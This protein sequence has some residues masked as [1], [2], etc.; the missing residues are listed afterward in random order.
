MR[1]D[2]RSLSIFF[3]ILQTFPFLF[4]ACQKDEAI[5]PEVSFGGTVHV[6]V[7]ERG[8]TGYTPVVWLNRPAV[9]DVSIFLEVTGNA[10]KDQDFT[11]NNPIYV[12]AGATAVPL[13][14][15]IVD[16]QVGEPDEIA[17]FKLSHAEG[18]TVL[19]R[20]VNMEVQIF[21]N[22]PSGNLVIQTDALPGHDLDLFLWKETLTGSGQFEIVKYSAHRSKFG[23][24]SITILASDPD[25]VYG[26]SCVY[27]EGDSENFIFNLF[28]S[29]EDAWTTQQTHVY[30][31]A[32]LNQGEPQIREMY[33]TKK[34]AAYTYTAFEVPASG[35]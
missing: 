30:S 7:S 15:V 13:N 35:S 22:D 3:V 14:L 33:I 29:A 28:L 21:D 5:I 32:N 17:L 24:E 31:L 18:G 8:F 1:P 20:P 25:G 34:G 9:A 16:D 11:F 4:L 12:P 19:L 2:R 26:V 27:Y 23:P 6:N 10:T